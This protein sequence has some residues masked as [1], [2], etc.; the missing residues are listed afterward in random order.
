M[1]APAPAVAATRAPLPTAAPTVDARVNLLD[2]A[3]ES[4]AHLLCEGLRNDE[5][6]GGHGLVTSL[7]AEDDFLVEP[8]PNLLFTR[9]LSAVVGQHVIL[10]H[11]A[12]AARKPESA[13]IQTVFQHHALF[14]PARERLI[15]LAEDE[16]ATRRE[17]RGA[18]SFRMR[19]DRFDAR[20]KLSQNKAPEVVDNVIDHV[21]AHNP[22]LAD[23]MK[24]V[25]EASRGE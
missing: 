10:S 9:D 17:A 19:V 7:L 23:E 16:A 18:V 4:L 11:A 13:L 25:R 12:T 22:G 3:P 8:L 6:R 14:A 2:L 21:A 1:P 15:S 24:R 20:A 5:V